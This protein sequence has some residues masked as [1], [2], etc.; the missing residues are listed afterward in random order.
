MQ[1]WNTLI[2]KLNFAKLTLVKWKFILA[3]ASILWKQLQNF[4]LAAC[5]NYPIIR[6]GR[7]NTSTG[8]IYDKCLMLRGDNLQISRFNPRDQLFLTHC[9][10]IYFHHCKEHQHC[11]IWDIYLHDT[12]YTL[13]ETLAQLKHI[14]GWKTIYSFWILIAL[15]KSKNVFMM[16]WIALKIHSSSD[17]ISARF[18]EHFWDILVIFRV[19]L[20]RYLNNRVHIKGYELILL[21]LLGY[22]ASLGNTQH[23]SHVF[24]IYHA[25]IIL[26]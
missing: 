4:K 2:I 12:P 11:L 26:L 6:S 8:Y 13:H 24:L 17:D 19:I 20:G 14:Y 22:P 9:Y 1:K 7:Y 23:A 21:C 10:L 15:Y 16:Y 25:K 5:Y 18:L 3:E